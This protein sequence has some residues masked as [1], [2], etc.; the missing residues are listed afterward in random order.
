MTESAWSRQE[1]GNHYQQLKIQPGQFIYQNNLGWFAGNALKYIV[2]A[3]FKGQAVEDLKKAIHY[4]QMWLEE[5]ENEDVVEG[6]F[7]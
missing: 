2:R 1:G 6:H 3:P 7:K 4:L 5:L